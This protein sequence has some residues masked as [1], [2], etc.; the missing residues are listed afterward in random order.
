MAKCIEIEGLVISLEDFH[1]TWKGFK[2]E[3][4]RVASDGEQETVDSWY[5]SV[6]YTHGYDINF[7]AE[8]EEERDNLLQEINRK[9]LEASE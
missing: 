1:K 8:N 3:L 2:K 4:G 6:M 5:V 7:P 9:I